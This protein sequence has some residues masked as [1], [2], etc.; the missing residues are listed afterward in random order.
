MRRIVV[1]CLI[2]GIFGGCGLKGTSI[3]GPAI[4]PIGRSNLR[5]ATVNL[6]TASGAV[7]LEFVG[8]WAIREYEN[9]PAIQPAVHPI[10]DPMPIS[11]GKRLTSFA[12]N[13]I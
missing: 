3:D 8:G 6:P 7:Q 9:G 1:F 13:R 11:V 12:I 2:T 10:A 4:I 5:S